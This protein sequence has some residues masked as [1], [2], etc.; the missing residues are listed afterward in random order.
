MAIHIHMLYLRSVVV[1]YTLV[2]FSHGYLSYQCMFI[3]IYKIY[4]MG[5][6][7]KKLNM[8]DIK[9]RKVIYL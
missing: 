3:N 8:N 5:I 1:L 2:E 4:N 7:T 9:D 6:I